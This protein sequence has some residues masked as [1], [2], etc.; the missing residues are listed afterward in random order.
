MSLNIRKMLGLEYNHLTTLPESFGQ[1]RDLETLALQ[2]NELTTLPASFGHLQALTELDI[3]ENR[4]DEMPETLNELVNLQL[5][6]DRPI[7]SYGI[8][9]AR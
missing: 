3:E 7:S 2:H 9:R 4:F 6:N 1:L 8:D 5:L